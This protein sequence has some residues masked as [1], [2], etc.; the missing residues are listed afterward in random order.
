[1]DLRFMDS[2][3]ICPYYMTI[4]EEIKTFADSMENLST[5]NNNLSII[6]QMNE[7]ILSIQSKMTNHPHEEYIPSL[8]N[9]CNDLRR[10]IAYYK[11]E[12]NH[13]V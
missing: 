13:M 8:I 9:F 11:A 6:N 2:P 5:N 1:M 12:N 7:L 3:Q 10:Y 4:L